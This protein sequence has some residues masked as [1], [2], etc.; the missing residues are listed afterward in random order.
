M[1]KQYDHL[2]HKI[3]T[4]EFE[5]VQDRIDCV[6]WLAKNIGPR[7]Q[8]WEHPY[9]CTFLFKNYDDAIWFAL[10]WSGSTPTIG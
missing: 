4:Q 9:R 6:E 5:C 3:V 10:V 8:T 7:Y 1:H 2:I